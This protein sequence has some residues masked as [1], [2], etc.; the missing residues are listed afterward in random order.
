MKADYPKIKLLPEQY[1]NDDRAQADSI[2]TDLMEANPTLRGIYGVDS[3]TGQGVGTAIEA[4]HKKGAVKV[5]AIDAEPQE[6]S[7]LRSGVIEALIAQAPYGMGTGAVQDLASY[8]MGDKSA[9]KNLNVLS[10]QE[11]TPQ[12]INTPAIEK[13]VYASNP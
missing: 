8:L 12:N 11:V 2:A 9:V 13:W 6:V 3:F 4:A 5:V 7:L 10:P 1:D